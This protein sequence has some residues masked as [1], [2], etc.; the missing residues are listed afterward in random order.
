MR[1]HLIFCSA[2]MCCWLWRIQKWPYINHRSRCDSINLNNIGVATF[3][4]YAPHYYVSWENERYGIS[5]YVILLD[6]K[7]YDNYLV[8]P[9]DD[10]VVNGKQ[11]CWL[12]GVFNDRIWRRRSLYCISN[13]IPQDSL[14]SI[15][16]MI[17]YEDNK[18]V[19]D[20]LCSLQNKII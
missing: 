19:A 15:G 1:V 6:D 20:E 2:D 9:N 7:N 12:D 17:L 11:T 8:S 10:N 16:K 14:H 5:I 3:D 13:G 18:Y 4:E